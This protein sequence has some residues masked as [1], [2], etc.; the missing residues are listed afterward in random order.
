[1]YFYSTADEFAFRAS[2]LPTVGSAFNRGGAGFDAV[3]WGGESLS[4]TSDLHHQTQLGT[5]SSEF[6]GLSLPFISFHALSV[7]SLACI[8]IVSL[9]PQRSQHDIIFPKHDIRQPRFY[10]DVRP[11]S[12]L[13]SWHL[14]SLVLLRAFYTWIV[15][16]TTN[17]RSPL[18]KYQRCGLRRACKMS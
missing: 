5:A 2:F 14:S 16:Y 11:Q 7:A 9:F 10:I 15:G 17:S 8:T 6:L 13:R 18:E 12:S 1:M 3:T 4:L